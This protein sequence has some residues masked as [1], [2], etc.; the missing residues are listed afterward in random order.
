MLRFAQRAKDISM[1]RGERT[2]GGG[3]E[4]GIDD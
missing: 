2:G 4:M 1:L 3:E